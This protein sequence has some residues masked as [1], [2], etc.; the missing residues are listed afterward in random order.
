MQFARS[1]ND[2]VC[3]SGNA[4]QKGCLFAAHEGETQRFLDSMIVVQR[5]SDFFTRAANG[6]PQGDKLVS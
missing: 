6:F 1:A 4:F 2:L 3:S 5:R